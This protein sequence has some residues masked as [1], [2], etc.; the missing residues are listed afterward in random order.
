[1]SPLVDANPHFVLDGVD[2]PVS[3]LDVNLA[4]VARL[5]VHVSIQAEPL[6]MF[7]CEFHLDTRLACRRYLPSSIPAWRE[8]TERVR[9]TGYVNRNIPKEFLPRVPDRDVDSRREQNKAR[10]SRDEHYCGNDDLNTITFHR[11]V[12]PVPRN[13][14]PC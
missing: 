9:A 2:F 8:V 14:Y 1:M 4:P 12:C 3:D 10:Q 7:V 11:Q 5:K 6:A 13:Q